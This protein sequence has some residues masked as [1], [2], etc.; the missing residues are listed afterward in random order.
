MATPVMT[1]VERRHNDDFQSLMLGNYDEFETA[2]MPVF[3]NFFSPVTLSQTGTQWVPCKRAIREELE[4]CNQTE[5][6]EDLMIRA[7][8]EVFVGLRDQ[9]LD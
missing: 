9:I 2:L 7:V 3:E 4:R 8:N 1:I 5:E 6:T